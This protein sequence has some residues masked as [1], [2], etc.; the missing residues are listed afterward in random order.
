[1]SNLRPT[2]AKLCAGLLLCLLLTGC[3]KYNDTAVLHTGGTWEAG[4]VKSCMQEKLK[5]DPGPVLICGTDAGVAF[6]MAAGAL[7]AAQDEDTRRRVRDAF[8]ERTK[9]FPVSFSGKGVAGENGVTLG[10]Y[11]CRKTEAKI[12]CTI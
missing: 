9:T 3:T 7:D 4:E 8:H 6:F 10:V 11:Q 2:T 12:D 1:M 5:G